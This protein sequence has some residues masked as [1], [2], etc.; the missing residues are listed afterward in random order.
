MH[1]RLLTSLPTDVHCDTILQFTKV[2]GSHFYLLFI[3]TPWETPFIPLN[4]NSSC[5]LGCISMDI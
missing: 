2:V 5:C 3:Y 1:Q 4:V